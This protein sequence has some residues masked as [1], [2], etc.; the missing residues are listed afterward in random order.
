MRDTRSEIHA[1]LAEQMAMAERNILDTAF[2]KQ[3]LGLDSLDFVE[4]VMEL[5]ERHGWEIS[6]SETDKLHAM[7]VAQLIAWVEK[8]IKLA[9]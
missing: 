1:I 9:A 4:L 5:E 6:E 3:D 7:T 2:L 8:K